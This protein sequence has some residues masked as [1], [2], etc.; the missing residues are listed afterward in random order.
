MRRW[1]SRVRREDGAALV[2]TAFVLPIMLLVSVGIF[3]FGRAYQTW[4]VIT[5]A[6]R[7]GARVAVLPEY[8]D[9][10]VKARVRTYLKDGGL[11]AA[12][13]DDTAKTNVDIT[14]TTIPVD[15][16]GTVTASAARVV[17]EYPFEFMVL[18]PVAQ[19]VVNGSMAGEPFTMR[20]TTI[21]RNE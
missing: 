1:F 9:D 13:V 5:N 20:M 4:Q 14:A 7:E 2:E 10:S 8:T 18:Q 3:E 15:V 12:I 6:T 16:G 11:P 17:V 21:M 19:L